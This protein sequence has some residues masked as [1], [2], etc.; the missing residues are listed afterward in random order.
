M[1]QDLVIKKPIITEKSMLAAAQGRFTFKADTKANK[2]QIAGAIEKL[3]NVNITSVATTLIKGKTKKF[4][5]KRKP[6]KLSDYKKAIVTLKKGQTIDIF[7]FE[8]QK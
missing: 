6:A 8:E 1:R 4:G 7:N 3:F 2:D 5:N